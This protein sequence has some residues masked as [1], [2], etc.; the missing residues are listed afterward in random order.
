MSA[1]TLFLLVGGLFMGGGAAL[2]FTWAVRAGHF[3]EIEDAKFQM[4]R[5][6]DGE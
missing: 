2:A 4:M 5:E 3:D 6:E 1:M